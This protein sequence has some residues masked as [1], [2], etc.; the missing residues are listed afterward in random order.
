MIIGNSWNC[1]TCQRH[2]YWICNVHEQCQTCIK[3]QKSRYYDIYLWNY[4]HKMDFCSNIR[5]PFWKMVTPGTV[6]VVKTILN[7]F[8]MSIHHDT[9]IILRKTWILHVQKVVNL[10]FLISKKS[11]FHLTSIPWRL[12]IRNMQACV[13]HTILQQLKILEYLTFGAQLCCYGHNAIALL[14][15]I[16]KSSN[17]SCDLWLLSVLANK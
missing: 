10:T 14:A 13:Y 1:W 6:K 4:G 15:N 3:T 9:R 7:E 11:S 16:I 2:L 5:Q 17:I 12:E 8:L